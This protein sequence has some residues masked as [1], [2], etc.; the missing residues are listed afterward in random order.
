MI[1]G[2]EISTGP[3][4]WA[5]R[6]LLAWLGIAT[7]ATLALSLAAPALA[8]EPAAAVV[9]SATP[10]LIESQL[11]KQGLKFAPMKDGV[12]AV[13]LGA[14]DLKFAVINK[15]TF[16][17]LHWGVA[18]KSF[19]LDKVNA[20]NATHYFSRLYLD[21]ESDPALEAELDLEAGVAP[22]TVGRFIQR[23]RSSIVE[24]AGELAKTPSP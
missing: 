14:G 12:Y 3:V 13:E 17:A 15:G 21:D 20:W 10:A 9:T 16:L 7:T 6:R 1:Q 18:M 2:S 11:T 24:L 23:F 19:G 8:A 5:I 22:D 4:P